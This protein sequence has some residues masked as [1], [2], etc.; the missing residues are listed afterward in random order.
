[1]RSG[2]NNISGSGKK[3]PAKGK[4]VWQ[5][6][7][8][9]EIKSVD[10]VGYGQLHKFIMTRPGI[11]ATAMIRKKL[12]GSVWLAINRHYHALLSRM[13]SYG[14]WERSRRVLASRWR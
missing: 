1:M 7:Y 8:L 14:E 13:G 2:G 9:G 6:K 12:S 10:Y 3:V 5:L 4:A 11:K